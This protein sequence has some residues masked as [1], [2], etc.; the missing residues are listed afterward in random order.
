MNTNFLHIGIA[1]VSF[2]I[3]LILLRAIQPDGIIFYQGLFLSVIISLIYHIAVLLNKNLTSTLKDPIIIFLACYCFM[4]TIPTTVDRAYSVMMLLNLHA[5]PSGMTRI[6]IE[7]WFSTSFSKQGSVKKRLTEQMATGTIN[8]TNGTYTL[9]PLG[10][11]LSFSFRSV[12]F[13]FNTHTS[14]QELKT[15]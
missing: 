1:I 14:N 6:E 9:T 3:S 11:F 12:Q 10:E 4:F 8:V 15:I 5:H 13:L 7:E 2:V